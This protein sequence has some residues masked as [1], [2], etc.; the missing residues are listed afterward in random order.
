MGDDPTPKGYTR[1]MASMRRLS[2]AAVVIAWALGA[3]TTPV[4]RASSGAD[5]DRKAA[6]T[7]EEV[8]SAVETARLALRAQRQDRVLSPTLDVLVT[9]AE[10]D[11][12]GAQK[13]FLAIQPKGPHADATRQ[14]LADLVE[15]AT[16][17]LEDVRIAVRRGDEDALRSAATVLDKVAEALE[18]FT[19]DVG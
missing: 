1:D 6:H 8:R 14:R 19:E 12:G 13:T 16:S 11:A 7:G 4:P 18:A 2:A 17:T 5:Y 10:A 9:E 15:D 3:C